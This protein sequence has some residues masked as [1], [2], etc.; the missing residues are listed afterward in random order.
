M[1][2]WHG[3]RAILF[4]ELKSMLTRYHFQTVDNIRN[5]IRKSILRKFLLALTGNVFKSGKEDY[6]GVQIFRKITLKVICVFIIVLIEFYFE[7]FRIF[8]YRAAYFILF[9]SRH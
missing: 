2:A 1:F 9:N 8:F 3:L 7:K 4:P 6:S 5:K